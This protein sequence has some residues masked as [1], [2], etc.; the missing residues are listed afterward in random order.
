MLEQKLR[1]PLDL[2]GF[3]EGLVVKNNDPK[4]MGRVGVAIKK[5]MPF[6][7]TYKKEIL[8][9]ETAVPNSNKDSNNNITGNSPMVQSVNYLWC[10]RASN[11][12]E[13]CDQLTNRKAETGSFII[14]PI[15]A[16][17]FVI[18]LNNDIQTPYYLPFGPSVEGNEKLINGNGDGDIDTD[19]IHQT[20]NKDVLGFNN[21]KEEF[22][23]K[24]SDN[25]GVLVSVKNKEIIINT[26]KDSA[27]I[28][29]K[30][31]T[32]NI[33]CET[34]NIKATNVKVEASSNIVLDSKGTISI[35]TPDSATWSPNIIK[36]CPIGNFMHGGE[37]AGIMNLKGI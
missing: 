32:I 1:S 27:K 11:R 30:D 21:K 13:Q 17:V 22:Y 36:M 16:S 2:S 9:P 26:A 18:F 3:F 33:T 37:A 10:N 8:K 28:D 20:A 15:G 35:K 29:L 12:F 4:K 19:L 7:G 31:D 24:M 25:S 5:L 23:V 14:P 6:A 34:A